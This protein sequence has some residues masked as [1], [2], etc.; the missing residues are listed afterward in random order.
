VAVL[1]IWIVRNAAGTIPRR[2]VKLA[3]LAARD[4]L[5][6]NLIFFRV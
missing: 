2:K 4:S 3:S 5:A 1:V 6:L